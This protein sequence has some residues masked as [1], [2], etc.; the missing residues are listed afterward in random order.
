MISSNKFNVLP[1]KR[2]GYIAH[3]VLNSFYG[4]DQ[5][6]KVYNLLSGIET[7]LPKRGFITKDG[8]LYGKFTPTEVKFLKTLYERRA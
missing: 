1:M 6:Q 8:E 4:T 5:W 3:S 7:Y 2:V